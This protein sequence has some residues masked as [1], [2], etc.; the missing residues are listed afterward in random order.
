M[1]GGAVPERFT[2]AAGWVSVAAFLAAFTMIDDIRYLIIF[3]KVVEKGSLTA[4]AEVLDL[5][6]STVSAHL[7]KLE[8]NLGV[9]LIYRNTR[10]LALTA[11][12]MNI[13]ETARAMLELYESGLL[14]FKQRSVSTAGAL[15]IALPSVLLA[16][17]PFMDE[18]GQFALRFNEASLQLV[19]SDLRE[20]IVGDGVDVAFRIGSL[21]DSTL[22]ARPV[23]AFERVT[24]ASPALLEGAG[25]LVHPRQLAELP[26]IGL[27]MLP[28]QRTFTHAGG[29]SCT[30][31][32]T[33]RVTVDSV[34]ASHQLAIAGVGLAAPP[35]FRARAELAAGA[36][37]EVLPGWSQAPLTVHAVWPGNMAPTSLAF[38]LIN[39]LHR[40]LADQ[41]AEHAG[42]AR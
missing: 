41:P 36:L 35:A 25:L 27:S 5:A 3:A 28:S 30:I 39:Q 17:R 4:A 10:K 11:D 1:L 42:D 26:W 32:Y 14:E 9:A 24:V 37:V 7:S 15:R 8:A 18:I 20:D 23:F 13:L 19:C 16:Y 29:E 31:R 12:G 34:E 22:K 33:P 21:P 2:Q 38:R 6:V 40:R